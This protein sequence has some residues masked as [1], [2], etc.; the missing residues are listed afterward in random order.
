[1]KESIKS[2]LSK[3]S[4]YLYNM[5]IMKKDLFQEYC[6]WLFDILFELEKKISTKDYDSYQKR[7]FGFLSERLFNI[8]LEYKK[9]DQ[10]IRIKELNIVNIEKN[11][12]TT[13]YINYFF[14]RLNKSFM[15]KRFFDIVF[16]IL[17]LII[18][19]FLFILIAI[20]IKLTD[21]KSIFYKQK[22]IGYKIKPF[23]IIK[24]RTM[25]I[26]ADKRLSILL[27]H[28]LS[29]REE[30]EK[31]YKLKEDP[32]VTSFG[33]FLRK[34]SLDEIPQFFNVLK[35]EMSI[36][37]P[38]PVVKEEL[39]KYYKEKKYIFNIT[40]PGITGLW[41]VEARNDIE[42]YDERIRLDEE[43]IRKQSFLFD[44]KIIIK[45]IKVIFTNKGAY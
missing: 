37:G 4:L 21:G 19:S 6:D 11:Y 43:Y 27:K 15:L 24:F 45:T 14:R 44:L 3:N 9:K 22:R 10:N 31:R 1:M 28:N 32:R 25:Y 16:S 35:G 34:T 36:V 5:F 30:W 26:D 42:N 17:F 13:K 29:A 8:W 2:S 18:F 40:K 41:Q 33:N 23:N 12:V 7:V 20:V 38:R 39:E